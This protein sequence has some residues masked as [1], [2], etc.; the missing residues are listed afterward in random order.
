MDVHTDAGVHPAPE[1]RMSDVDFIQVYS[2][3]QFWPMNPS[4][5]DVNINDIAHSL[6][7]QCRYAGHCLQFYSVA[8]HS[9]HVARWLWQ[10]HS[11]EVALIGLLHDATEAYLVDVP[12]PVKP[13]LAGYRETEANLWKKAIAPHFGLPEVMP[14]AV[15]EADYRILLD[16]QRQNMVP[17]TYEGGWPENLEPLGIELEF[18]LPR[19]AETL[20]LD[21]FN[22]LCSR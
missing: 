15:H 16:E 1:P 11:N 2:G 8:E 19:R 14:Q 10:R 20:F 5:D 13:Q 9:I 12:R 22:V 3:R 4:P 17:A 18:L 7:M 21:L 6:S